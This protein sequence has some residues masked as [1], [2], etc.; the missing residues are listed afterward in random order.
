MQIQLRTRVNIRLCFQIDIKYSQISFCPE[1]SSHRVGGDGPVHAKCVSPGKPQAREVA[2]LPAE[3]SD[4]GRRWRCLWDSKFLPRFSLKA[5]FCH[6]ARGGFIP[7]KTLSAHPPMFGSGS[8]EAPG[9]FL[10]LGIFEGTCTS[11]SSL[12]PDGSIS[13]D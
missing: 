4:A 7:C 11:S 3:M 8:H 9:C 13:R 1:S 5:N 6:K 2:P 12:A 10:G